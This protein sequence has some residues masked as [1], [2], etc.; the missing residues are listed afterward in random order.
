MT[1][2]GYKKHQVKS[3]RAF[4]KLK[5]DDPTA[6]KSIALENLIRSGIVTKGGS[7]AKRYR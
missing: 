2:D 5:K 1:I 7:V 3:L 6:A 4:N